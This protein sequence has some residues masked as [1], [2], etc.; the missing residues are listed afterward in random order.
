MSRQRRP[1]RLTVL[2]PLVLALGL[3]APA[4]PA[5]ASALVVGHDE[6]EWFVLS[7][8]N[9]SRTVEEAPVAR[10]RTLDALASTCVRDQAT[11]GAVSPEPVQYLSQTPPGAFDSIVLVRRSSPWVVDSG[12]FVTDV[13]S[14][15]LIMD[16]RA[17]AMTDAGVAVARDGTSYWVCVVLAA[18][19]H[20]SPARDELPLYRFFRPESG[21]H[22]YS[23]SAAERDRV[24]SQSW[25]YRYE[26]LVGFVGAPRS[27]ASGAVQDLYRFYRP[28]SGTHFYT[29]TR[30]EFES[31]LRHPEYRLDGLAGRVRST[32]GDG[33]VAMHR[34]YRPASGTHFYSANATE[35][36]A[37][38][39]LRGY[40][41]EGVAFYLR[42]AR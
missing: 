39:Q 20:G 25:E 10:T 15:R 16:A 38:K 12:D 33:L 35:V 22:L 2:A 24:A 28:V 3:L 4:A 23:T 17:P 30:H 26:G 34:F 1:G 42:P 19:D 27:A 21:T 14:S 6:T 40:T 29:A 5:G 36:D 13:W 7:L 37:V 18:Y 31:V 8:V 11:A 9:S 41:Y 32:P